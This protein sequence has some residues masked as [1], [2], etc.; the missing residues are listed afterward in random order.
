MWFEE[1][2]G[3]RET[4]PADVRKNIVV[5][6]DCL[7]SQV[8]GRRMAHGHLETPTVGELRNR[9]R[10]SRLP[11]GTIELS[12]VVADVQA[13][14]KLPENKDAVFQVASQFNLLEMVFP[15][16]TPEAGISIYEDDHTQGPACAIAC[17][18]GTIYRNYFVELDGQIGQSSEQQIDCLR[19]LGSELG[20][21]AGSLWEMRNGYALPTEEGLKSVSERLLAADD[22]EREQ[23][24]GLLRVGCHWNTEVTLSRV[25]HSVTQVYCSALPVGYSRHAPELWSE[26]AKLILDAA[27]EATFCTALINLLETGSNKLFLTLLGGG[28]FGNEEDW[29]LA[30]IQ[31]AISQ[32]ADSPLDVAIV[33]YGNSKPAVQDLI[34]DWQSH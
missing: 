8:N 7:L 6:G 11:S 1:L 3:F 21:A 19:D 10:E 18:A 27:Y 25:A 33:S 17:G 31:R 30:A 24:R 32:F 20:N 14:H 29:I 34:D 26:F 5:D 16:V 22:A 23:L 9:V 13:L 15:S 28:A 2:T 4:N 12:E